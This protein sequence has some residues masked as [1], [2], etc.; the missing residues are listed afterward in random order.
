MLLIVLILGAL[1]CAI[2]PAFAD[3]VTMTL[4]ALIFNATAVIGVSVGTAISIASAIVWGAVAVGASV[5]LGAL[6]KRK[7]EMPEIDTGFSP[8]PTPQDVQQT[9]RQS[10]APRRRHYGEVKVGGLLAFYQSVAG[11]LYALVL[12]MQGEVSSFIE[13]WLNDRRV[14]VGSLS[15]ITSGGAFGSLVG[16]TSTYYGRSPGTGKRIASVTIYPQPLY[17]YTGRIIV[18]LPPPRFEPIDVAVTASLYAK[19][20]AAPASVTD[21]VLLGS[22]TFANQNNPQTISSSDTSTLYDHVW[23]R[24]DASG[25]ESS[26]PT[27]GM[28]Q[29]AFLEATTGGSYVT[30]A[31]YINNGVSRVRI[32]P[33]VGTDDQPAHLP[34]INNFPAQWSP[35]HRAR[36]V[37]NVLTIFQDVPAADF[38][39]VYPQNAPQYRAV[40]AGAKVYDPREALHLP[41]DKRTWAWSDNAA[42]CILD[43]LTH[44]DGMNRPRGLF[45]ESTFAFCADIC[46]EDVPLKDG[47]VEKRYRLS[48]SYDLSEKPADVLARMLAVCDGEIYQLPSGAYGLRIGRWEEPTVTIEDRHILSYRIEQGANALAAFNTLKITYTSPLHDYQETEAEAWIDGDNVLLTTETRTEQLSLPMCPSPSQARRIGK[49]FTAKGNPKWRGT[50]KTTFG[51]GLAAMGERVIALHLS[52]LEIDEPFRLERIAVA[53]DLSSCELQVSSLSSAAY[54]W[55]P[56]TDEGE[57]PP[58]PI[59]A[60]DLA[61]VTLPAGFNVIPGSIRLQ[62]GVRGSVVTATWDLPERETISHELNYRQVGEPDWIIQ[63]VREGANTWSSPVVEDGAEYEVRLR[64]RTISG[65]SSEWTDIQQVTTIADT[66]PPAQQSGFSSSKAG[67]NVTLV[68]T[69]PNSANFHH[70]D[71]YRN[72][73]SDFASASK[74]AALNGGT[75]LSR[76]YADNGLVDD[77]YHWWLVAV[78]A[79]GVAAE[80]VGPQ[81][82]TIS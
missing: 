51:G 8:A 50:V 82:Q 72:T 5:L 26:I 67:S 34:L 70:T 15:E 79:S 23:V 22:L 68:W 10:A 39:A 65:R 71:I 74:I 31:Q 48:G 61:A 37:A 3:P 58:I 27:T 66:T 18:I 45:E 11:K 42:L 19:V 69:N 59:D 25:N 14:T 1:M 47:G 54:E 55:D 64:A 43:Y 4:S 46:D 40:I 63:G 32:L 53:P 76:S 81:S 17:Y 9:V 73:V 2:S 36:G 33:Q 62:D 78:N 7:A 30:D 77:T 52:E 24:L 56:E 80:P 41:D 60:P 13:H 6:S 44:R 38:S 21:G 57:A 75:G 35:A 29:A 49:I 16:A 28:A 12:I 20:G